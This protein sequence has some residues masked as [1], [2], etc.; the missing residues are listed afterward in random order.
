MK[1]RFAV[2]AFAVAVLAVSGVVAGDALKS[3]V[4]V[5]GRVSAFHP[6]NVTGSQAGKKNCLVWNYGTNPVVVIFARENNDNLT[7]LV[8]KIDAATKE[9]AGKNLK[10]FVTYLS[11]D[12]KLEDQ[13]K[14]F[15][16][17][18]GIKATVLSIDNPTGPPAYKIAKEADVTVLMYRKHTVAVNHAFRKGQLDAKA[19]ETVVGD[20][21]KILE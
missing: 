21:S 18:E 13:L 4:P 8:K 19:I 7:S 11:D 17:K 1:T 9:N 10:S 2:G 16:E 14:K 5:K 3:G 12:E 6:L 20:V 15:A